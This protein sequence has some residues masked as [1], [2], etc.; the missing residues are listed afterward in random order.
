[1]RRRDCLVRLGGAL[2]AWPLAARAQPLEHKRIAILTG[3]PRDD[4]EGEARLSAFLQGMARLGWTVGRDLEIE[5]RAAGRDPERYREYAQ[6]LVALRPDLFL[7]GGTPAVV[8]LQ[9][10]LQRAA[11]CQSSSPT[12]PTR[13]GPGI[14][15]DWRGRA[16]TPRE[17]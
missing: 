9:A 4:P 1:M 3:L 17:S 6:E 15:P 8:S 16:A 14:S 7:A 5:H 10:A 11:P 13:P 2:V 12:P